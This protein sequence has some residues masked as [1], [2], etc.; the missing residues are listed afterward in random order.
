MRI[1][2]S[3]LD[4]KIAAYLW[5]DTNYTLKYANSTKWKFQKFSSINKQY[6]KIL[7]HIEGNG[8]GAGKSV[9]NK[10]LNQNQRENNKIKM[11]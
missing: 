10:Y 4:T 1:I 11:L 3:I 7:W 8:I 2:K 5:P 9:I 6:L